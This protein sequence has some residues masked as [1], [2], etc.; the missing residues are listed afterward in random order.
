VL[1]KNGPPNLCEKLIRVEGLAVMGSEDLVERLEDTGGGSGKRVQERDLKI[2][3]I[4]EKDCREIV[5]A[6]QKICWITAFLGQ[7]LLGAALSNIDKIAVS[8]HNTLIN[9]RAWVYCGLHQPPA[10]AIIITSFFCHNK[11]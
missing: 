2:Q 11:Y 8:S 10:Q 7:V 6:W 5:E 9:W 3:K 1:L 4:C